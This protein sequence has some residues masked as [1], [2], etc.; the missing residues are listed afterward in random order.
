MKTLGYLFVFCSFFL[1]QYFGIQMAGFDLTALRISMIILC[2]FIFCNA[3]RVGNLRIIIKDCIYTPYIFVFMVVLLYTAILRASISTLLQAFIEFLSMYLIILIIREVF[4]VEKFVKLLIVLLYILGV[5]GLVE[6]AMEKTMFSYLA[7]LPGLYGG[8][9]IRSGSYRIMGPCNHAL[10]Y[11]LLLI[12]SIPLVCINFENNTVNIMEHKL[13]FILLVM[14]VFLNGSRSTLAVLIVEI[15]LLLIFST[16]ESRKRALMI[17]AIL[18]CILG[19][20]VVVFYNSGLA[21][22]MLRQFASLI[23]EVCGT[24]YAAIFGAEINRLSDSSE[25]RAV[26]PK[27]FFLDYLNPLLGRGVER[28]FSGQIDGINVISVDNFYVCQYIRYAYPGLIAYM[29]FILKAMGSMIKVGLNYKSGICKALFVGSMCYFINLWWL[30][31]L[32]TL[33]YVY[34]LFAIYYVVYTETVKKKCKQ[35]NDL[36][37]DKPKSRYIIR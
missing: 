8:A 33:K 32:Q 28:G 3:K 22:Y 9:Y 17:L 15:I 27:I 7:T 19:L 25:Y 21:Q 2:L 36:E 10:A 37:E 35:V 20:F 14:N 16:K 5:M 29:S 12:V 11:G 24:E 6:Y 30:D 13:L 26:L 4:G 18:F 1:P 23:D 31:S 34:I